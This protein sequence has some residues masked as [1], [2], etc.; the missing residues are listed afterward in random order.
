MAFETLLDA[1]RARDYVERG[2]WLGRTLIDI[3]DDHV[4]NHPDKL[5]CVS[6]S[7]RWTYRE[8]ADKVEVLAANFARL[9]IGH[10]DVISV[11]LP[12]WGEFLLIHL[13]ATRIGAVTNGLLPIYRAKDISYILGL[14]RSKVAIIPDTFRNYDYTGTY[15]EL[16]GDLPDLKHVFVV[17]EQ[18]PDH[19]SP[20]RWWSSGRASVRGTVADTVK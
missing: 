17:G 12:N 2:L 19:R 7:G 8:V 14:A 9:G 11:Q 6:R 13:A 10:G 4:A 18:H 20:S 15:R 16:R 5:A 1:S 3:F